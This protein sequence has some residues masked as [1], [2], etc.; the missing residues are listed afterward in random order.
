MIKKIKNPYGFFFWCILSLFTN[1]PVIIIRRITYGI[2]YFSRKWS[3]LW[4][5]KS[6]DA[7]GSYLYFEKYKGGE[8]LFNQLKAMF[9]EIGY[10]GVFEIEFLRGKDNKLYFRI[11]SFNIL[12]ASQRTG[13]RKLILRCSLIYIQELLHW[14][15]KDWRTSRNLSFNSQQEKENKE[16]ENKTE[17]PLY[18]EDLYNHVKNGGVDSFIKEGN[19]DSAV[20]DQIKVCSRISHT[21]EVLLKAAVIS[22]ISFTICLVALVIC[23]II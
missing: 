13:A 19:N 18:S 8:T 2:F 21:K 15:C 22:I 3:W 7:Y 5:Y 4:F 16:K 11:Y 12:F 1:S 23:L 20:L 17:Y 10:S 14:W 6:K 9:I